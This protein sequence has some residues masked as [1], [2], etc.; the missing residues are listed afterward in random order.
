MTFDG[1]EA[2]ALATFNVRATPRAARSSVDGWQGEVLKVH[3][4]APP[5]D[6]RANAALIALLAAALGV[7]RRKVE[8][9]GGETSRTKRVRVHGLTAAQVKM[10]LG[11]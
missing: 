1:T 6:G 8:I 7:G 4:Q 10:R 11:P 9:I 5:M 3:L 2:V